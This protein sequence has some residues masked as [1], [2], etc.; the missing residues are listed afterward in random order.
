ML[1][2]GKYTKETLM[3]SW[4]KG[5]V[6]AI[7]LFFLTPFLRRD[8]SILCRDDFCQVIG[9]EKV[10]GRAAAQHFQGFATWKCVED[11]IAFLVASCSVSYALD[12]WQMQITR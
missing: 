3:M 2:Q 12:P 5:Y 10:Q 1:F 8:P 9:G 6:Y 7:L 11:G 4:V